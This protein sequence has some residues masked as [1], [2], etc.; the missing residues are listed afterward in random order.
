MCNIGIDIGCYIQHGM[1]VPGRDSPMVEIVRADVGSDVRVNMACQL[2]SIPIVKCLR[3]CSG[4]CLRVCSIM[5]S[6]SG[7]YVVKL[8]LKI[9]SLSSGDSGGYV[10]VW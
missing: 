7:G 10:V 4:G 9:V 6:L 3:V 2:P 8:R 1:L 5:V